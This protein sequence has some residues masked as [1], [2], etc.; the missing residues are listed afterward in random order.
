MEIGSNDPQ[1][2]VSTAGSPQIQTGRTTPDIFLLPL[3]PDPNREVRSLWKK[4]D[5]VGYVPP[6]DEQIL[7]Y[8]VSKLTEGRKRKLR[9][10]P[11]RLG[12]KIGRE[13]NR[14]GLGFT[15]DVIEISDTD[16]DSEDTTQISDPEDEDSGQQETSLDSSVTQAQLSE[17]G[18]KDTPN[19]S[20]T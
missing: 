7:D 10:K 17:S 20:I 5:W 3:S 14:Q 15:G 18:V 11:T 12:A 1:S 2:S 4:E 9:Q 19:R 16:S 8:V 6:T 13:T